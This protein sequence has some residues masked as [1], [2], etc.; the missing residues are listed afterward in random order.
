MRLHLGPGL[1]HLRL[2]AL[3]PQ[4]VQAFLNAKLAG[5]LSPRTVRYLHAILRRALG[6]AEKWG[7]VVR[8]VARLV[9]PP[10]VRRPEV[11][12]LTLEE[13]RTFLTAVQGHR[14]EAL[15]TV[16]LALGRR[17]GEVL[18]LRWEDVDLERGT[19]SVRYQL[20]RVAGGLVVVAPKSERSR[21]TIEL[22]RPV[23]EA[24][25]RHRLRQLE[26]R[27]RAG[28]AWRDSGLVFTSTIGMPL[29]P[30]NLIREY[31][32]LLDRAGLPRRPFHHL[33]HTAALLLAQGS[34]IRVVQQVL[35]HSQ[36]ALTA[37]LYAPCHVRPAQGRGR[38]DGDGPV[39][40]IGPLA[41]SG[42]HPTD[43]R[44]ETP[45]YRV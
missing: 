20:Q 44:G 4:H 2:A 29:E 13:A 38:E 18:G 19:L 31:H 12:P 43:G 9:D 27:L 32:A 30:R 5:G 17:Q 28:E 14:L 8:N 25:R 3:Q 45:R 11:R 34:D 41:S 1:G 16:A 42:R 39:G 26:E 37:D 36:I 6:Q 15:F 21:R 24:L 35:G 40:L 23:V 10:K 33:R 7:L 22:P